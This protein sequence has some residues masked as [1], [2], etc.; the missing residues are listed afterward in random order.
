M[1]YEAYIKKRMKKD[2]ILMRGVSGSGK[3]TISEAV[4]DRENIC[5]ADDYFMVNGEYK[6]DATKLKDAHAYCQTKCRLRM[7]VGAPLI[8]VANTFTRLWEMEAYNELAKE[9]GYR[10]HS[11]IVENRHGGVNEHGVP[12]E[13]LDAMIK[14][15]EIKL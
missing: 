10:V 9:F 15:F 8:I 12:Q 1:E 13:T 7:A 6:F 5:T 14:R 11:I 3:T 2:L 4:T